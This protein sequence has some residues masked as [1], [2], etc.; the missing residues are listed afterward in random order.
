[1]EILGMLHSRL[2]FICRFYDKAT[3][4]FETIMD[5]IAAEEEP[6]VPSRD[7]ETGHRQDRDEFS[8]EWSEADDCVRVL[9]H[10]SLGLLEK[11]L[12]DYLRE[13]VRRECGIMAG[14]Y[15]RALSAIIDARLKP[16]RKKDG[17]F[18]M[19]SRFLES[20]TSFRWS[21]AP[22]RQDQLEQ[23]NLSRNDITHDPRIDSTAAMQ[24]DEHFE[25]F[26]ISAFADSLWLE[27]MIRLGKDGKPAYPV[28]IRVTRKNLMTHIEY[29]RLFCDFVEAHK[30]K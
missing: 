9:G 5:L 29:V 4:P 18:R 27:G 10:C 13:F 28:A 11:A 8:A 2:D 20:H 22:V 15:A 24:S 21:K 1:M 25:K 19:Y 16:Y 7:P 12:H 30:T 23:I 26:P 3:A 6:Y 17:W 14:V